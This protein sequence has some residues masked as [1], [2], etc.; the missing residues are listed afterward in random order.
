[1]PATCFWSLPSTR[2]ILCADY[3]YLSIDEIG[4][5]SAVLD[6]HPNRRAGDAVR[7][8]LLTGPRRGEVLGARWD[9]FDFDAAV[10]IK[11]AAAIKQRRRIAPRSEHPP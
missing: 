3:R 5:L 9:Q 8:I 2:Q 6:A 1:M 4:R 10:W 7:L 11:P